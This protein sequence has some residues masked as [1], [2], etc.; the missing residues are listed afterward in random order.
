M[1]ERDPLAPITGWGRADWLALADRM[2]GA[3]RTVASPRHAQ[4]D[5]PGGPGGRGRD[6][7]RL[8]G[9]ART[10][11]LAAFRIAGSPDDTEDLADWYAEG[12]DAGTDPRS[13]ERW[14]RLDEVD[15]AKVEA[16]AIAIG[17]H[18]AR[19]RLWDRLDDRVRGQLVDWLAGFVG[20]SHP[21]NNWAWFR[22]VVEQFLGNVGGPYAEDDLDA[23]LDL[24]DTFA[25]DG[26]WISDGAARAFDHYTG[27]ALHLYPV[28]WETML[29]PGD[30]RRARLAGVRAGLDAYLAD[31]VHLVGADGG[32]LIQGRSLTYRFAAA[33]PFWAGALA[34]ST[35]LE[36]GTI[37]RA[38]SGI[39]SHFAERGAPDAEGRL[40]LG[41]HGAWR[42]IAQSYSG[43]GSPYWAAKGMLGIALPESHPVWQA[44]E[45]PLPVER[46]DTLRRL[47]A[48]GWLVSGTR[49]DGIVRVVNHGTDYALGPGDLIHDGPL[50][51][52]LGYS[53]ATAPL[54]AGGVAEERPDQ[55]AGIV[56][57]GR[58]SSRAGFATD[59]LEVLQ[60]ED[61]SPVGVAISTATAHW[62]DDRP[63]H[64]DLGHPLPGGHLRRGPETTTVS[65]VRGPWEVRLV[66]VG[67]DG[68]RPGDRV[69]VSGWP[70]SGAS[71]SEG[72]APP[73]AER[74]AAVRTD[75]GLESVLVAVSGF[76]E[77]GVQ[78][79]ADVTFLGPATATPWAEGPVVADEWTV[80]IIALA[81]V[82]PGAPP[83]VTPV[84]S[85]DVVRV[86]WAD[87]ARVEIDLPAE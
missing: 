60:A 17:L 76:D 15:Q 16:A 12:L 36:P 77:T 39:V 30:P 74:A 49:A 57:G 11:L 52:R 4:L 27:W 54:L 56:R 6:V 2:L 7:D 32:P 66:R 61:G 13:P 35:A 23:D 87:G 34:G 20:G 63:P 8:E 24:L 18:L 73:G 10:F 44:T 51:A 71:L 78:L 43:P 65:I 38:A 55:S 28:L 53:T 3:A 83:G 69:R 50:Y 25:R 21:P 75:A 85:A 33:A 72:S 37:R 48:P 46:G 84:P 79:D 19:P 14:P 68:L 31:A 26:G 1:S 82:R 5:F 58:S 41:W 59:R 70:V 81:G 67:R 29:A 42:A 86:D 62:V 9:F 22:I 80:A 47:V 64:P 40:S 45:L